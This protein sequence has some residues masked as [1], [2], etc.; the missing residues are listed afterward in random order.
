MDEKPD[1]AGLPSTTKGLIYPNNQY[2]QHKN[3]KLIIKK[4]NEIICHALSST[5]ILAAL[6]ISSS[7]SSFSS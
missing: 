4:V 7:S 5:F 6:G 3:P 1:W 2:V